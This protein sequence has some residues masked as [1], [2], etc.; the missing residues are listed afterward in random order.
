MTSASSGFGALTLV[1]SPRKRVRWQ[2]FLRRLRHGRCQ[3]GNKKRGVSQ[4]FFLQAPNYFGNNFRIFQDDG[5]QITAQRGF[6]RLN[7]SWINIELC[8]E[9]T[10]NRVPEFLRTVDPLEQSL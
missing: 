8:N 1:G 7:E 3:V 5:V 4:L 10:G 9:R 6:D 2:N